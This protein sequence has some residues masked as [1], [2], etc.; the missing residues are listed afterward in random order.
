MRGSI[1]CNNGNLPIGFYHYLTS[2]SE[3]ETQAQNFWNVIQ[4]KEYQILPVLDV[5]QDNLGYKAQSYSERFMSEFYRLSGQNMIIYSGRCY[6][7]EH[8]DVSI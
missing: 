8:F 4:N 6:I 2:T 1:S 5:E 3:P 7:S